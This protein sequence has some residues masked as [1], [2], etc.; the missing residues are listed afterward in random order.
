[1]IRAASPLS[2]AC[3]YC[4]LDR[5]AANPTVAHAI[6]QEFRFAYRSL[7]EGDFLEGVRAQVVDKDRQPKW[8]IA[9]L[10][11]ITE[12]Q[13]EKMLAPLGADALMVS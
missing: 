6:N 4:V 7:A 9:A 1:M 11:D 10:E 2:V 12:D 5:V 13:I 8:S 3:C